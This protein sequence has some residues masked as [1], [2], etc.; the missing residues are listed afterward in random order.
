MAISEN[1][2][3]DLRQ[4]LE[5]VLDE[6]LAA[7]AMEAMPPLEYD[8]FATK[9][10][11]ENLEIRLSSRIDG[12]ESS[13]RV[14]MAELRGEMQQFRGDLFAAMNTQM[15]LTVGM[16]LAMFLALGTWIAAVG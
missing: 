5:Q 4:A 1:E 13:M 15:R 16:N 2:R 3:L 6:R 9:T 7:I 12:I 11:L 14:E 10:D 8:Q